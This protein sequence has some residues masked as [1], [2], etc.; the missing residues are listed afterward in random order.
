MATHSI[1]LVTS[2]FALT[3]DRL[4]EILA[5]CVEGGAS[6]NFVWPFSKADACSYWDGQEAA[7][8]SGEKLL[9]V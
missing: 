5:D 9:L 7:F 4:A 2:D 3:F 6:V 1:R 8:S